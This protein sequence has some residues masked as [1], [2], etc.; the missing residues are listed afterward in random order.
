[1]KRAPFLLAL[2]AAAGPTARAQFTV[3]HSPTVLSVVFT[4]L[5]AAR[6]DRKPSRFH[7]ALTPGG[8]GW[9]KT[10][11][12]DQVRYYPPLVPAPRDAHIRVYE[13][14]QPGSAQEIVIRIQVPASGP[15]PWSGGVPRPPADGRPFVPELRLFA[16]LAEP[17][18]S[19]AAA[20]FGMIL[21][22][23]AVHDDP[24]M[25]ALDGQ[26]LVGDT[27][28]LKVVSGQ[29]QVAPLLVADGRGVGALA[30]APPS[31]PEGHGPHVVFTEGLRREYGRIW[32]LEPDWTATVLAG[33]LEEPGRRDP[34]FRDG[35]AHQARFGHITALALAGDGTVYVADAG[36][37][38]IRKVTVDGQVSTVAGRPSEALAQ[39]GAKPD[40]HPGVIQDG[41]GPEAS[42]Q[43]LGGMALDP[44]EPCLYV[45]DGDRVRRVWVGAGPAQGL[46]T[47]LLG[48]PGARGEARL[49]A[50]QGLLIQAGQLWIA[51]R[52]HHCIKRFDPGLD[53]LMT[54]A[55]DPAHGAERLGTLATDTH[56]PAPGERA[57]LA[58]PQV[59]ASD[60]SGRIL[61]ALAHGL[62]ELVLNPAPPAALI[63]PSVVKG[64]PQGT[65]SGAL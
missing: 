17:P 36:N 4:D 40:R 58:W 55:G 13:E 22:I 35:P 38:L 2:L 16:G 56:P 65:P 39:P 3:S 26:W 44:H 54:V 14:G 9:L 33:S 31:R 50:P 59:L 7:W 47:T 64:S 49:K 8:G 41:Q 23:A 61:V 32:S 12:P 52:G 30:A 48:G 29:G 1:M 46:V 53:A 25:G 10:L 6:E 45:T 27:E 21:G 42:F 62:G 51:D 63:R 5:R 24:A 18:A 11:A 28:G 19:P 34:R 37:R 60:G 15:L 57:T 43:A 20:P